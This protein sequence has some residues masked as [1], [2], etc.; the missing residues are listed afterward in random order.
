MAT[1]ISIKKYAPPVETLQVRLQA[2][3]GR[4]Q[5]LRN[6]GTFS[7]NYNATDLD[8]GSLRIKEPTTLADQLREVKAIIIQ[9]DG[10]VIMEYTSFVRDEPAGDRESI[11]RFS[12]LVVLE[13]VKSLEVTPLV[14]EVEVQYA[15]VGRL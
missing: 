12:Q 8:T 5:I 11:L 1:V 2:L 10:P 9:V 4:N 7:Q 14:D 6:I 3:L 13:D 15:A